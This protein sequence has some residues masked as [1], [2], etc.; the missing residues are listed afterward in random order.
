MEWTICL[1]YLYS[2]PKYSEINYLFYFNVISEFILYEII[3]L[4]FIIPPLF[5]I[6]YVF[7]LVS[8]LINFLFAQI[9]LKN[10]L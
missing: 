1:K 5:I 3:Y 6:I 4:I 7:H 8:K 10:D 9:H 2:H